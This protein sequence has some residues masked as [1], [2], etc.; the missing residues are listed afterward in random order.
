MKRY[1]SKKEE[2]QTAL[3]MLA[4]GLEGKSYLPKPSKLML[5]TTFLF[6]S[7]VFTPLSSA[8][9]VSSI[10]LAL[11]AKPKVIFSQ[12]AEQKT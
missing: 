2:Y 5:L 3:D 11:P 4:I 9:N 1:K 12:K 6:C 8:V 7:L 10:N